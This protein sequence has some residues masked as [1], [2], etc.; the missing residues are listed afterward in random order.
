MTRLRGR[1]AQADGGATTAPPID[2][3]TIIEAARLVVS[4]RFATT[5]LLERRLGISEDEASRI[6]GRLEH[7]EVV[8]PGTGDD[9][10]RVLTT[11]RQLP[12]VIRQFAARG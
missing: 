9:A 5:A 1:T 6:L 2:V 4:T 3:A 10:R 11:S 8:A 7:C 12:E